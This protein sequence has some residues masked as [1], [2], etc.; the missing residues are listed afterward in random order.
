MSPGEKSQVP[1]DPHFLL[2]QATFLWD[3]SV[4]RVEVPIR[5]RCLLELRVSIKNTE[6]TCPGICHIVN[7]HT[8]T[9]YDT[10]RTPV[11]LCVKQIALLGRLKET[12]Y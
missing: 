5:P 11:S 2:E 4:L 3:G 6:F 1:A 10:S 9:S 7:A 8:W 12:T